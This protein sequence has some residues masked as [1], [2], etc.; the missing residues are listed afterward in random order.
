MEILENPEN[1][2]CIEWPEMVP[3]IQKNL[4]ATLTITPS[5]TDDSRDYSWSGSLDWS[6]L[7]S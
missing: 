6:D 2:C 3:M 1:F 5:N 7:V 4:D